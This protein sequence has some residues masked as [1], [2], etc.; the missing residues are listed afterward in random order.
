MWKFF[1]KTVSPG[2][3]KEVPGD[4]GGAAGPDCLLSGGLL[5]IQALSLARERNLGLCIT[6]LDL[7]VRHL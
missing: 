2:E 1:G 6:S 3:M 5:R 7:I 4:A